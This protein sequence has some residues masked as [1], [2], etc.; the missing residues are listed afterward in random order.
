MLHRLTLHQGAVMGLAF[1]S[2]GNLLA[3]LGG[4]DDRQIVI[5]D[6]SSGTPLTST[7]AHKETI[8]T[9]R[10]S[11]FSETSLVTAGV[12][13]VKKW[14]F[15]PKDKKLSGESV[16]F[17]PLIRTF[18]TLSWTKDSELCYAGTSSGDVLEVDMARMKQRRIGPAK[19]LLPGGITC[20]R[21]IPGGGDL[22]VGTRE[23]DLVRICIS[24]SSFRVICQS[25]IPG[26]GAI[27]SMSFTQ[28]GS[29]FFVG[30]KNSCV[31]WVHVETL[32]HEIRS[33]CHGG[34]GSVTSLAFPGGV[35]EIFASAAGSEVR[36]WNACTKN[37]LVAITVPGTECLCVIFAADCKSIL[38]G[39][40]DGKIRSFTPQSGKLLFAIQDAHKDGVTAIAGFTDSTRIISGGQ[41]GEVRVWRI[42]PTYQQLESS[43]KEHRL[44]VTGLCIRSSDNE[45]ALSC[46]ADG[47]CIVW[48]LVKRIRLIAVSEKTAFRSVAYHPDFSQF[49]TISSDRRIIYWDATDGEPLRNIETEQG[50]QTVIVMCGD[51]N[52]CVAGTDKCMRMFDYDLGEIVAETVPGAMAGAVTA[53]AI[54]P[55]KKTIVT[56]GKDGGI[57]FWTFE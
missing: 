46:S 30:T 5:W 14:V 42:S 22:V 41:N 52:F 50:E 26:A 13:H 3:T 51:N 4:K 31:Y 54:A 21:F 12:G 37:E 2:S 28:D 16:A 29:H 9:I 20:A 55:D 6:V 33:T 10:F 53:A 44:K 47:T 18:T 19:V 49:I 15:D 24:S 32:K 25:R 27:T 56:G 7:V 43:L 45:R 36:V 57:Y 1:S 39:W 38:T 17:G 35:S 40:N 34:G 8:Y 23:G 11:P 48:D